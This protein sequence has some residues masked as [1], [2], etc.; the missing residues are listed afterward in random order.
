MSENII[1]SD[2]FGKRLDTMIEAAKKKLSP[3]YVNLWQPPSFH[4]PALTVLFLSGMIYYTGYVST[5]SRG[6]VA[7]EIQQLREI[8]RD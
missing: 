6:L 5:S 8:L 7:N 2:E 3:E 4:G 1:R